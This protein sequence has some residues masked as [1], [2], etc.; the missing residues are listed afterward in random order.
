MGSNIQKDPLSLS[1]LF[2]IRNYVD[3][4][5]GFAAS[6]LNADMIPTFDTGSFREAALQVSGTFV[7]TLTF[8]GS[9]DNVNFVP[10][11]AV[12]VTSGAIVT[13]TSST[14]IF[15]IPLAVKYFRVRIT[16]YT[17]GTALGTLRLSTFPLSID[18]LVNT[19]SAN[20]GGTVAHDDIDSGSPVKI[21][22]KARNA[23]PVI[24]ATG[25]RVDGYYDQLGKAVMVPLGVRALIVLNSITLSTTTETTLLS[26]GGVGNYLDISWLVVT[27]TSTSAVRLDF[28]SATLGSV[29][30]PVQVP[31]GMT[32]VIDFSDLPMIQ[33]SANNNW[34]AQLSAAVTDVR[35]T[36]SAIKRAA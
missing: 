27:N 23:D 29:V 32:T 15:I 12:S 9:N 16:A 26:A 4:Y 1:S 2:A 33:I 28:R 11:A 22:G 31:A 25:D 20:V 18:A 13:M 21:G 6:A 19:F 17:S 36:A 5:S 24:V 7:G 34:T 10:I 35:V 30:L 14:G 3:E 8:Q